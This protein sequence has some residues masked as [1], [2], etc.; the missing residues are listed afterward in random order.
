[1]KL[2]VNFFQGL[3]V[4]LF[5]CFVLNKI[6]NKFLYVIAIILFS[7]IIGIFYTYI[8]DIAIT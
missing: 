5:S 6:K 8:N 7:I 3:F 2:I 1:M 4:V